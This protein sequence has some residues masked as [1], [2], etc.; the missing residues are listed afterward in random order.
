MPMESQTW[1]QATALQCNYAAAR[2]GRENVQVEVSSLQNPPEEVQ[3][4]LHVVTVGDLGC[5][6]IYKHIHDFSSQMSVT[7]Y[8]CSTH[9]G[10]TYTCHWAS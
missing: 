2:L 3:K 6:K 7:A 1:R 10:T 4:L 8:V 9:A 5:Y